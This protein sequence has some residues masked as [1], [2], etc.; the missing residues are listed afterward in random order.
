MTDDYRYSKTIISAEI[1]GGTLVMPPKSVKGPSVNIVAG[2]DG[3][4]GQ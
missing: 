1:G 4:A 2:E 3:L